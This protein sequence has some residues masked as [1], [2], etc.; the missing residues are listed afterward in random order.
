MRNIMQI[1]AAV[2]FGLLT[3]STANA[4]LGMHAGPPQ[5]HG[6]W[7]PVVGSGGVY[8]VQMEKGGTMDMEI[9]IVGKESVEGKDAY[10]LEMTMNRA[11]LNGQMVMKHLLVLDG[12]N[13]H[14]TRTIMQ[15]PGHPPM[16]MASQMMGGDHSSQPADIRSES[17]DLGSESITV[18][19]GTFTCRHYRMKD[20]S[21]DSWVTEKV[22]PYG[23]VKHQGKDSTMVLVKVLTNAKD[24]ITGTPVP[25]NPMLMMPSPPQQP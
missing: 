17:E 18:P 5:F 25:F 8:E 9:A 14:A 15:M 22:S 11:E 2:V 13:T 23:L 1:A 16:E 20:G 24:K 7:N 19:A 21:G 4:Q 6:V 12:Q 3:A 10:W